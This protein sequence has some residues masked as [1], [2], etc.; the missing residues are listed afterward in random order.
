MVLTNA[1]TVYL[2]DA[3]SEYK[4]RYEIRGGRSHVAPGIRP[5]PSKIRG[6]MNGLALVTFG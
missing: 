1:M 4:G 6:K 5:R 3:H 2:L